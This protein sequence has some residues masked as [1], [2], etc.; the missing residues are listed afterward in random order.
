MKINKIK[1][2]KKLILKIE[3]VFFFTLIVIIFTIDRISKIKIIK[4]FSERTYYINDYFNFDIIWNI[5]IGFGLLSTDSQIVYNIIS[6]LI[7][8]VIFVLLLFFFTCPRIDKFFYC[9]IIGGAFGNFYDR[10]M[11]KAVPDFIDFHINNFHWFTFNL[12][13]I[14]IS[15]GIIIFI[16][17]NYFVKY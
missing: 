11:F 9:M 7:G 5:G 17:R 15:F 13:D 3:N 12:A 4:D 16:F 2:L 6:L 1:D 10:I 14:F 8:I